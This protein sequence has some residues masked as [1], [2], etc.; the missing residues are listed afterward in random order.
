[1]SSP[2]ITVAG[3][4]IPP[5]KVEGLS[6]AVDFYATLP[7]LAG[8]RVDDAK[9]GRCFMDG[10]GLF[11]DGEREEIYAEW[12]SSRT[13]DTRCIRCLR[14]GRHKLVEASTNNA[15]TQDL[16]GLEIHVPYRPA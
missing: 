8:I 2:R 12:D 6:S 16:V 15:E 7:A 10:G 3:G 9:D 1:M 13:G 5:G 14:T 4:G 11:P